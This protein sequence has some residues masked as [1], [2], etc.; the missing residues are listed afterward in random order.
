MTRLQSPIQALLQKDNAWWNF[1][2]KHSD[3]I[4]PAVL[5][6]IVNMLSCGLMVRG[7]KTY[8]CSNNECSHTKKVSFG[9]K[10]RFCPT[11]GKKS[12]DE[13]VIK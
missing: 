9:C 2:N 11:C 12:T 10:S 1:Y 13:W 7:Y 3:S 8:R 5:D 6:N 4:R